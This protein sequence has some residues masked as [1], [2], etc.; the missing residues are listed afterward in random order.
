[1]DRGGGPPGGA[2][3]TGGYTLDVTE[4]DPSTRDPLEAFVWDSANN[5]TPD[6]IVDGVPTVYIY[7]GDAG[8]NFGTGETT[9][10]WQQHQID[11]V[12]ACCR[13]ASVSMS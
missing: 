9:Y 4:I 12:S 8:E 13:S 1:M 6:A 3:G 10:G 2:G 5:V 11:A 7:F